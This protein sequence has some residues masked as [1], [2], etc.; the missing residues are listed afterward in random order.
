MYQSAGAYK[1][2][3]TELRRLGAVGAVDDPTCLAD[4]LAGKPKKTS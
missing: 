3:Y 1:V 4:A 2:E